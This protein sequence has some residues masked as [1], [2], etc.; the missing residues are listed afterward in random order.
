[1]I[2][3]VNS[4]GGNLANYL[5]YGSNKS[6]DTNKIK[7]L[8]GNAKLT[9]S[10]SKSINADDKHFHFIIS[11]NGKRSDEA[12]EFIYKDFKKELLYSYSDGEINSFAV[13]HQ[14]TNNSHIHIQIPKKNLLTNTKLD[15]YFHKRDIK[16]FEMMR[17]YLN[18]KYSELPPKIPSKSDPSKN[19]KYN[20]ELIKT[21]K[22]KLAFEDMLLDKLYENKSEYNSYE[23][24]MEYIKN[25]LQ[26]NIQK[27]GYDYKKDGFYI[28]IK[29]SDTN[30]SQRVFS[31]LFN[32][33]TSKYIT[34]KN[35]EKEYIQYDFSTTPL[36]KQREFKHQESLEK[37][38]AKLDKM[39]EIEKRR[40]DKRLGRTK[41]LN[42][43][44]LENVSQKIN[45][46]LPQAISADTSTPTLND[47]DT[48]KKES[49][50][51]NDAQDYLF[52]QKLQQTNLAEIATRHYSFES[53]QK[54]KT[55]EV[56]QSLDS[57][58][59]LLIFN[60]DEANRYR[61][62]NLYNKKDKG[63]IGGLLQKVSQYG[64]G[65][66]LLGM[67]NPF[68]AYQLIFKELSAISEIS[69]ELLI[70]YFNKRHLNTTLKH[71]PDRKEQSLPKIKTPD[72]RP[73]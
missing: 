45:K 28:T 66:I 1:M 73:R 42:S 16:R 57:N 10:I 54:E 32:S 68:K 6:R 41:K 4:G 48:E 2:I 30:K 33:G 40:I 11:A 52:L 17:D 14:D 24:L 65:A 60:D 12:M 64:V 38:R 47:I 27:S 44:R 39:Q 49:S 58:E 70:D 7:I 63:D 29:H 26:I 46:D 61:Y 71:A 3:K 56:I 50:L 51:Q 21:K 36:E 23:E 19:W 72:L 53:V 55:Y 43:E 35:E 15:L 31:P 67:L 8:E 59:K 9:D 25:D 62:I 69:A 13:L 22:E 18:H 37:L 34:N 5:L 20:P